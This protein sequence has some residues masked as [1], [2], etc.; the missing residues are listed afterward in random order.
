MSSLCLIRHAFLDQ[1]LVFCILCSNLWTF[2]SHLR[3]KAPPPTLATLINCITKPLMDLGITGFHD[4]TS[5]NKKLW[6]TTQK[7]IHLSLQKAHHIPI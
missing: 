7:Q 4:L 6:E 2:T 5:A 3:S 1:F